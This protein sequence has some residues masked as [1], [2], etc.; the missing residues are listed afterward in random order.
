MSAERIAR[1]ARRGRGPGG[2]SPSRRRCRRGSSRSRATRRSPVRRRRQGPDDEREDAGEERA[3]DEVDR[4]ERRGPTPSRRSRRGSRRTS[5]RSAA[6]RRSRGPRAGSCRGGCSSRSRRGRAGRSSPS[7]PTPSR[8]R[9]SR[10]P[11]PNSTIATSDA[12]RRGD[13]PGWRVLGAACDRTPASV[14]RA[15][16]ASHGCRSQA[17]ERRVPRR[18]G[19]PPRPRRPAG[20]SPTTRATTST[21]WAET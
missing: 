5:G 12:D 18:A 6:R 20:R 14:G 15:S 3:R 7:R 11:F 17:H 4:D 21:R 9:V 1:A 8:P 13:Q 19:S 2:A 10:Q 16:G